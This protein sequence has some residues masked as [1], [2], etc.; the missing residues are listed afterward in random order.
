MSLSRM[1]RSENI[2]LALKLM[3]GELGEYGINEWSFELD[4]SPYENFYPTTWQY[5]E[6]Q[7]FIDRRNRMGSRRYGLTGYG[8]LEGLRITGTLG[9]PETKEKVGKVSG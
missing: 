4:K 5:L 9:A 2:E 6:G 7:Y 3:M 8:W 1:E